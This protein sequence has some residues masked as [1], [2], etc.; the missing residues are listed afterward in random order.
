MHDIEMQDIS[1]EFGECWRAAGRHLQAQTKD[2]QLSW[3]KGKLAPPFL[4]H[5][6]FRIGNQLFFVRVVDVDGKVHGP[7]NTNGCHTIADACNGHECLM[8]MRG[9]KK[10]FFS[11]RHSSSEW[12]AD[13]PGWGL[14]NP[15][16]KKSIDPLALVTDE[17]IEMTDWELHDFSVQ[18]ARDYIEKNLKRKII[19]SQGNP[20]VDPSIWFVGNQGPEWV[21]VRAARYPKKD[22]SIPLNISDIAT[23][24]A[25]L[26]NTG[27]FA[28]VAM[29][30][31]DDSFDPSKSASP[32]PLWRGYRMYVRFEGLVPALKQE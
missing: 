10:S 9:P 12:E 20:N 26:S 6:S 24:C 1:E 2:A 30:N 17:K 28:P 19:S 13:A 11:L 22:A 27:H 15:E 7:G 21:V 14:I 16:T 31:S 25:Q 4:E 18:V 8:P 3:L 23:N 29:A 5:L 32:L